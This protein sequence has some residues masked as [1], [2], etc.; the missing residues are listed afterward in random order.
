M[1]AVVT[2]ALLMF[3][4]GKGDTLSTVGL[5]GEFQRFYYPPAI[6]L[7]QPAGTAMPGDI[8]PLIFPGYYYKGDGRERF[9]KG[10]DEGGRKDASGEI[11]R[12][13]EDR[14]QKK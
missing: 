13:K 9:G 8:V 1:I 12:S 11:K 6:I 14:R 5:A 7:T 2:S 3:G 10:H 4:S